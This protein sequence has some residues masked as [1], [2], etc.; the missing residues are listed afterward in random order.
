MLLTVT[1]LLAGV[2]SLTLGC[3]DCGLALDEESCRKCCRTTLLPSVCVWI[4]LWP[5]TIKIWALG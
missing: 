2:R 3:C 5:S 1:K 4:Q